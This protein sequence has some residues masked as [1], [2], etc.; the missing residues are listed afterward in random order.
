LYINQ[1]NLGGKKNFEKAL[2]LCTGDIIFFSDQD[3]IW[4][5]EKVEVM[6][7]ALQN[8]PQY[9]GAFSDAYLINERDEPYTYS[10]LDSF[11][12]MATDRDDIIKNG[13]YHYVL[14]FSNIVA[15]AM[16]ALK[17]EAIPFVYPFKLMDKMWHDEWITL[18]LSSVNKFML[19]N[20]KL[21]K[22]R[23]HAGQQLGI[24]EGD[25][26]E[27]Y[28]QYLKILKDGNEIKK[29]PLDNFSHTWT[30]YDKIRKYETEIK[31]LH[32]IK[33]VYKDR[34]QHSKVHFLKQYNFFF[35]KARIIKWL[36]NNEFE[37]TWKDVFKL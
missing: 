22:Y 17:K 13:P 1:Q 6:V 19:V 3:D 37:T 21:V 35:R 36:I 5:P 10:F 25:N 30:A 23:L 14:T 2:S 27:S 8:Q 12:C 18:V 24:G 32:K 16:L 9:L 34:F 20:Q 15:G 33:N 11:G 26:N 31:E 7:A 29:H 28:I 4:L